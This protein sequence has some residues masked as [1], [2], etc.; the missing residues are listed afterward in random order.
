MSL[1]SD[2]FRYVSDVDI[3]SGMTSADI[4]IYQ[5]QGRDYDI[6]YLTGE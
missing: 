4:K 1:L 2:A 6:S 3:A 5:K